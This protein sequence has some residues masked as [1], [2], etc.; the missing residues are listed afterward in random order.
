MV[1]VPAVDLRQKLLSMTT[2]GGSLVVGAVTSMVF[3][4]G[5]IPAVATLLAA[6]VLFPVAFWRRWGVFGDED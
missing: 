6:I 1:A 5:R 3:D 2:V 4:Q